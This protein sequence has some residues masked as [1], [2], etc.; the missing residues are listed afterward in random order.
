MRLSNYSPVVN[1]KLYGDASILPDFDR[2][3]V[4][5]VMVYVVFAGSGRF[6]GEKLM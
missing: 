5:M 2:N 3:A 6:T 4:E 1:E